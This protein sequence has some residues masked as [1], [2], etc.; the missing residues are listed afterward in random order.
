MVSF[1]PKPFVVMNW[2]SFFISSEK[3]SG[4]RAQF[5]RRIVQHEP[6]IQGVRFARRIVQGEPGKMPEIIRAYGRGGQE[7]EGPNSQDKPCDVGC[8][9]WPLRSTANVILLAGE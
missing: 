1:P 5:A 2:K 7:R 3:F 4:F 6:F 8:V 9:V